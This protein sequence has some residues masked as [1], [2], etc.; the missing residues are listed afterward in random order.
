MTDFWEKVSK[1]G[2]IRLISI[3]LGLL[4]SI[5]LSRAL[6]PES[7]GLYAW[8]M[9]LVPLL[10]LPVSGGLPQLLV[11][12]VSEYTHHNSKKNLRA[13][14]K[15]SYLWSIFFSFFLIFL[16][17]I[18]GH[19]IVDDIKRLEL[20][21]V[22]IWIIPFYS[23]LSVSAGILRGFNK[24]TIADLIQQLFQPTVVLSILALIYFYSKLNV[25]SMLG[26]PQK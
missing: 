8:L 17:Y 16:V 14:I 24:P 23:I 12:S 22:A 15:L 25:A 18:F 19:F 5:I 20:L 7:F 6:G 11:R 3:P 21:K 2:I 1:V 13:I 4:I 10:S 9:A 26:L